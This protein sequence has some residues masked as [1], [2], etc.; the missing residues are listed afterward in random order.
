MLLLSD[1][2]S[3]VGASRMKKVR[4][5]KVLRD[6]DNQ[7]TRPFP[8]PASLAASA[9]CHGHAPNECARYTLGSAPSKN[10]FFDAAHMHGRQR[11]R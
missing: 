1:D 7:L 10:A 5:N 6:E 9:D 2:L 8:R 11:V 3:K 4:V